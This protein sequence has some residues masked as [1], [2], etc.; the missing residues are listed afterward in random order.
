VLRRS[1]IRGGQKICTVVLWTNRA[2]AVLALLFGIASTIEWPLSGLEATVTIAILVPTGITAL[3]ISARKDQYHTQN[4]T[5][6][7]S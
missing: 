4:V 3:A 1:N 6:N 5:M 7:H 2:G